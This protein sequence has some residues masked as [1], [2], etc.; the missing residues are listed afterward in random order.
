MRITNLA[1]LAAS[2]ALFASSSALAQAATPPDLVD[3]AIA[4]L[5]DGVAFRSVEGSPDT[6]R[7]A[8]YLAARLKKGG[9]PASDVEVDNSGPA[10]TLVATYQ[11][12]SD[13]APIVLSGHMDVVEAKAEDW[14]RNPFMMTREGDFLIGRG[15]ID[16]KWGVTM[17]VTTLL[18]LKK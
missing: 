6:L 9:F 12:E 18:R 14:G 2:L 5:G 3:E 11:G 8:E 7:Y 17:M 15:A 1:P 16:N 10:P 4:L 13:E